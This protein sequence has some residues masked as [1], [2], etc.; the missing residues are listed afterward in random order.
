MHPRNNRL[1][2][3][4]SSLMSLAT[5]PGGTSRSHTSNIVPARLAKS[6]GVGVVS[7]VRKSAC[8]LVKTKNQSR[9]CSH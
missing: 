1:P 2:H 4:A 3:L 8:D 5:A 9:K 6:D 7:R